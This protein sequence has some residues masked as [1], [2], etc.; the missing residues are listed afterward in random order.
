MK[1]TLLIGFVIA[2]TA[3]LSV[4]AQ[5][6]GSVID[7]STKAMGAAMLQ[8]IR[9]TGTGTNNSVG[10]AFTSGGPWPRYRVTKYAALVNYSVPAMRQEIIRIDNEFPPRGG[11]AVGSIRL[12]GRAASGR[13]RATSSKTKIQM[14]VP[15]LELSTFG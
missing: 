7:A 13:F 2:V 14:G 12:R 3:P 15:R 9:Y 6:A 1:K 10:Q 8:S 11:G 5:D 4:A